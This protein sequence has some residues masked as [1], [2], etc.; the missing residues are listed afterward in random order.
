MN[1]MPYQFQSSLSKRFRHRKKSNTISTESIARRIQFSFWCF[2]QKERAVLYPTLSLLL[3]ELHLLPW[4]RLFPFFSLH[5]ETIFPSYHILSIRNIITNENV[6]FV[7]LKLSPEEY[8]ARFSRP[9]CLMRWNYAIILFF[10]S[11]LM[12]DFHN[13]RI[14]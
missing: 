4:S 6:N 7:G 8:I 3:L 2:H 10:S 9:G 5:K 1:L 13:K 12:F 14:F 11:F